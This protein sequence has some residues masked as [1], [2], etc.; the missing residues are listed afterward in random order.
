MSARAQ[1]R[2]MVER[3]VQVGCRYT[4]DA[5]YYLYQLDSFYIEIKID[6]EGEAFKKV[7]SFSTNDVLDEY[8][9]QIDLSGLLS[10][11]SP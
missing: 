11:E 3:A 10:F 8:L 1:F 2:V 7:I 5:A 4:F 9:K 6:L